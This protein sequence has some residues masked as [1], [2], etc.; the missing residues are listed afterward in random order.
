MGNCT[1]TIHVTGSHHN[2]R[3]D[4]IDAMVRTFVAEL[5]ASGHSVTHAV[6]TNGASEELHHHRHEAKSRGPGEV[7]RNDD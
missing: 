1:I 6:L 7:Y 2:N 4:D 5:K 3:D